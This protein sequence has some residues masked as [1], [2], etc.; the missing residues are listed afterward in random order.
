MA[1]K[2]PAAGSSVQ[3]KA[4]EMREAQEKADRRTRNTIVAVVALVIL[5][6]VG[7]LVFVVASQNKPLPEGSGELP[8]EFAEGQPIVISHLGVGQLD[9]DL[10][11]L[12]IYFSYSCSWCAYLDQSVF[13]RLSADAINGDYNLIMQPVNTAYMPFQ[14]PATFA[15]LRVAAGAP[16]RFIDFHEGLTSFFWTA[17]QN[18]DSSVI[19]DMEASR[20]QI[21][22]IGRQV[23]IPDD[24][25]ANFGGSAEEYLATTTP[26]WTSADIAGRGDSTGTPEIVFNGT[27]VV[28]SQGEPDQIYNGIMLSLSELGF[29]PGQKS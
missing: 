15:S 1:K 17:L 18:D 6:I 20:D 2:K 7:A 25:L 13:D 10:P 22:A 8:A 14:D 12:K 27:K 3:A 21:L 29:V 28:W 11:D 19:G 9:E 4:R 26:A 16:D 24:V 5:A 23:G